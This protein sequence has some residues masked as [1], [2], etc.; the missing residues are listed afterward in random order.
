MLDLVTQAQLWAFLCEEAQARD[1][2]LVVVSHNRALLD[3]LC[4]RVE[5]LHRPDF[6]THPDHARKF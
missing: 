2:G 6:I 1:I 4:S 5:T 3:H